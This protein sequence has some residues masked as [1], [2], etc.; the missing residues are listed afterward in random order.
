MSKK[1]ILII[2]VA[3]VVVVAGVGI[4]YWSGGNKTG[5][6]ALVPVAGTTGS[7]G[8]GTV[9]SASATIQLVPS[10]VVVPVQNASSVPAGVAAPTIVTP[11][12]P[13]GSTKYR[14]F[15]INISGGAYT[16]NTV[17]V[18]Q[19]DTVHISLTA[20]GGSY[21][22]TQPNYGLSLTI[23]EG[24]TKPVQFDADTA[25][26][27]TFYCASCGGPAKGPTGYIEVVAK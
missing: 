21:D 25:G 18:N 16:P 24:Q 12:S 13:S 3:V 1:E 2:A 9:T 11:G 26:K 15:S 14:S 20:V 7:A 8:T 22:F 27:F 4:Y 10:N 23:P 5:S 19:G 17:I 6:S